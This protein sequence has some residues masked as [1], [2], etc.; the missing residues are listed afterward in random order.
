MNRHD[1]LLLQQIKQY[2][3]VTITLPTH[4]TI[5]DNQQ[6]PIRLGNLVTEASDRLLQEFSKREAA[7][8]LARLEETAN[9]VDHQHNLDGLV[10][11]VNEDI[12]FAYKL[13]FTVPARV[14]IDDTFAT[15][16]LV[17]ALNRTVRYWVLALSENATRLFEATRDALVE[18][19][20]EGF[21]LQHEGP[22]A[23]MKLPSGP[24]N[25]SA[26]RDEYHRQFFRRV[27]QQLSIFLAD[28]PL[29]VLVLGV[30]RYLAFFDEVTENRRK[31]L[32]QIQGNYDKHSLPELV[33]VVWPVAR[34]ALLAE[35]MKVL[36]KL[37]KATNERRVATTIDDIWRA[38]QEGRGRLLIVEENYHFPAHVDETGWHLT[39]AD[40]P[41]APNVIDD[42]VDEMIEAVLSKGGE[43]AF[44]P[45]G[46]L[47]DHQR[48]ALTLRY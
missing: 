20:S 30:D 42:A 14:T 26:Y 22:G 33:D 28:D 23:K 31:I 16:K 47:N 6:D 38:A 17:L 40:D 44:V 35:H 25:V 43:V 24:K 41:T 39:V 32:G 9:N 7:N 48:L 45:D 2:P 4:R 46:T 13:P 18:I 27:D 37:N 5:P 29:P 21:P 10:L 3:C 19:T 11:F 12:G 15:R 34:E 1:V 36:D 8:I